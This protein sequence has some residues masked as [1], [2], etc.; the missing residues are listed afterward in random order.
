MRVKVEQTAPQL[1]IVVEDEKG[2]LRMVSQGF[3]MR[4]PALNYR[5]VWGEVE[6]IVGS[7]TTTCSFQ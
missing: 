6:R 1:F 5:G 4:D 3:P 2:L 7:F